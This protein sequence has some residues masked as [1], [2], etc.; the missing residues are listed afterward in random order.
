MFLTTFAIILRIFSNPIANTFEKKVSMEGSSLFTSFYSYM[1]MGLCCIPFALQ[2]NWTSLPFEFWKYSI[3]A[4]MLCSLGRACMV[5]ALQIG[6]LSIL[7]PINS[8]K[9]VV[10]LIV[11]IFMLSEIPGIFGI[12]GMIL[13]IWG[14]RFVF[15]TTEEGFSLKLLKR[16]DVMLRFTALILTGIEAVILKKV[17]LLSSVTISFFMWAWTGTFF[18]LLIILFIR[19]NFTPIKHNQIHKYLIIC[20]GLALMQLSTNYVFQHMKVGYALALFQLSTIVNLFFGVKFFHEQNLFQKLIGTV[21]M[22]I[23]SVIIILCP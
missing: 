9:S 1:I 19:K 18:T 17:I 4:G 7:G 8:Y 14:S 3:I 6:E 15:E 12:L 20:A 16:K 5:K 21:I 11:G 10:G 23:G 22:M 13:I 2:V